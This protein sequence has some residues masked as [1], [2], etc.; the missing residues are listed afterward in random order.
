MIKPGEHSEIVIE[1]AL[2]RDLHALK[3]HRDMIPT[4]TVRRQR[5]EIQCACR[6][7]PVPDWTVTRRA[8]MVRPTVKAHNR[9]VVQVAVRGS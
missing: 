3:Y 9:Q 8:K 7:V 2:V 5:G 6:V 4:C 1:N